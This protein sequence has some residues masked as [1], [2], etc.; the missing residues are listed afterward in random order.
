LRKDGLKR[1]EVCAS[2][3]GQLPESMGQELL[4]IVHVGIDS[5]EIDIPFDFYRK[6]SITFSG[7]GFFLR[8]I[9]KG[10]VVFPGSEMEDFAGVK[11]NLL[12][13]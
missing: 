12:L 4:R 6:E 9:L 10:V 1:P 7:L 2:F 5:L 8:K 13:L 11:R 3:L